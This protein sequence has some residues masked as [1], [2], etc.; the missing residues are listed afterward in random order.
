[1]ANDFKLPV[2]LPSVND[3]IQVRRY[4]FNPDPEDN[5]IAV[6][7]LGTPVYSNLVFLPT[8]DISDR[9][10]ID[11]VLME[12][13]QTKN[14]VKT[15]IQGR[16]GT[17]KEYISDGDYMVTIR[18]V[19]VSPYP[20]VFPREDID[21]LIKYCQ[22]TEQLPVSSFFLDLFGITDIVIDRYKISEKLGSRN[23]VPFEIMAL[24]DYPIEFQLN[25]NRGL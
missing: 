14:I 17:V 2:P 10:R 15:D 18:G 1:M 7:Y 6:S 24:S 25:P 22:V 12:V 20:N 5:P 8:S 13:D 4:F 19:I 9:L 21:L 16:N 3:L 11:T 23:E